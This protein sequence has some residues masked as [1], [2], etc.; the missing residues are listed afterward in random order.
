MQK[1]IAL[2]AL[3]GYTVSVEVSA[4]FGKDGIPTAVFHGMGDFCKN[5]GMISFTNDIERGTGGYAHCVPHIGTLRSYLD[6]MTT[7]ASL[8]CDYIKENKH[9]QGEFNVVGLS[10]GGLIARSIIE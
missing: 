2:A 10:Q 1:S 9:F 5:P 3:V 4:D 7:Q 6:T 8:A